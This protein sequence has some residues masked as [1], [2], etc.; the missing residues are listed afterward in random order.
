MYPRRCGGCQVRGSDT[1]STSYL[2]VAYKGVRK[3]VGNI[4][5]KA[6]KRR[7]AAPSM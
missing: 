6:G 7:R 2:L 3:V 1:E 4:R 5:S